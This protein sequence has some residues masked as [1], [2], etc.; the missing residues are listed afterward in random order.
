MNMKK[1]ILA[2]V[3]A[4]M[5][6]GAQAQGNRHE[7]AFTYGIASSSQVLDTYTDL[8]SAPFSGSV[9]QEKEWWFGPLSVEYFYRVSKSF[10]VGGIFVY[11]H[12]GSDLYEDNTKR[13]NLSNNYF[14]LMPGV[15]YTWWGNDNLGL[16][17]KAAIGATYRTEKNDDI[18]Y[19]ESKVHLN[20][21]VSAIG[22][23]GGSPK[24]R[25]F[26]ELGFGEQGIFFTGLRYKF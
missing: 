5:T 9:S 8:V 4:A 25:G 12:K 2:I 26:A 10:S 6:L 20:F 14:T 13:G 22:F 23:E 17:S 15:K 3:M 18:H 19:S 24:V 7:I 11:G 21:Q 1:I 16:Y